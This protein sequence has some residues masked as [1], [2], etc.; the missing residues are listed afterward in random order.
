MAIDPLLVFGEG[1]RSGSRLTWSM[2]RRGSGDG[3]SAVPS[4]AY[5]LDRDGAFL[6]R[7][8]LAALGL[9]RRAVDA[10]FRSA[11]ALIVINIVS[12]R[13][14]QRYW[15]AWIATSGKRVEAKLEQLR[16][17]VVMRHPVAWITRGSDWWF[18]LAT[19]IVN[20]IIVVA[21]ARIIGGRPITERRIV[22][23]AVAYAVPMA[24]VFTF[25]GYVLGE[26]LRG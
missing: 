15:D 16:K 9:P 26:A 6:S 2:R 10:V 18:A 22:I 14:L 20:P 21:A 12:C 1:A 19:A 24:A 11:V 3:M 17:V 7:T 5:R 13:W 4:P 25:T 23:A 8:D